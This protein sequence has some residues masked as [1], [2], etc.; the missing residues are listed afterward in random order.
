[1]AT[2]AN[3]GIDAPTVVRNLVVAGAAAGVAG[4]VLY[5]V[6]VPNSP[7]AGRI[8]SIAGFVSSFCLLATA[9]LMVWGSKY[10]KLRE[11]EELIDTLELSGKERVLDVGC[12]RGLLL[13][14]V[15]RRLHEGKAYGVDLWR[16][17]DQSGNTPEA[18]LANA[19]AENVKQR[20]EVLTADMRSL[21]FPDAS[22]DAVISSI[23]IHNVPGKEGRAQAVRE[24]ARVLKPNGRLVIRDLHATGEYVK[25]LADLGW[26][27]VKLSGRSF[28]AVAPIRIV[29]AQKPE[30][31]VVP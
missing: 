11:R 21:P 5:G 7:L 27:N 24:I 3:Y 25:T 18:A 22:L 8:L 19:K 29:T 31:T 16:S 14:G 2:K 15:A 12:G 26:E 9:G 30:L 13:N 10:G 20:V 23:A 28:M 1:M 17:V 6:M 4:A